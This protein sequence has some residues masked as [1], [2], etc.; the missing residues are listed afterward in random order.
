MSTSGSSISNITYSL[1]DYICWS[2]ASSYGLGGFNHEGLAWQWE[3]PKDLVGRISI[4]LLEFI[5]SVVTIMISLNEKEK[6]SKILAFADNSSALGWLYKA[7]FHPATQSSHD[8][9]A[10]KFAHFMIKNKFSIY[11]EYIKG[12]HN[13][14][15][16][17]LSRN[18]D[19]NTHE[20]TSL[21]YDSFPKQMPKDFNII[22]IPEDIVSWILSILRDETSKMVLKNNHHRRKKPTFKNGTSS[23]TSPEYQIDS[24][25]TN[26]ASKKR[27][28]YVPS[29]QQFEGITLQK[30]HKKNIARQVCQG[31]S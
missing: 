17:T 31:H 3:V 20:L 16:D 5:A 24:S 7:S 25:Q 13:N 14:V 18:F 30:N 22:D 8:K 11:S 29:Q 4:N 10:R 21:L 15:A 27:K 9:V 19:L 2:D 6:D 28:F 26:Q 23:V 1:P 12:E